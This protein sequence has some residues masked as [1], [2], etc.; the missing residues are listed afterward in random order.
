MSESSFNTRLSSVGLLRR[1]G[2]ILYDTLLLCGLLLVATALVLPLT[3]GEAVDSGNPWFSGYLWLV[4][5][6]FFGWFWTH[7]GQT[8]GM[9]AWKLRLQRTDRQGLGWWQALLRFFLASLWM[10][11]MSYVSQVL[12]FDSQLSMLV[13]LSFFMLM[14]ATRFHDRYS[15]TVVVQIVSSKTKGS[16]FRKRS[17]QR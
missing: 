10:L 17:E 5:F 3:A 2:A 11:P 13:G 8:L 4:C 15:D 7:G 14:L 12:G 6:L 9:R 1:C 16:F